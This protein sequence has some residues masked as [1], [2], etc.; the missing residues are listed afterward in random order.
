MSEVG[1]SPIRNCVHQ[2]H[3]GCRLLR[4][5]LSRGRPVPRPQPSF[6]GSVQVSGRIDL[7]RGD[8][9]EKG[10]KALGL[11]HRISFLMYLP[12]RYD[13]MASSDLLVLSSGRQG[14]SSVLV[15]AMFFGLRVV[16]TDCNDGGHEILLDD[17]HGTI[18][19]QNDA[20]VLARAIEGEFL[21]PHDAQEQIEGAQ[22][23]LPK[24]VANQFI[25]A[26][27]EGGVK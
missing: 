5:R 4:Q 13:A 2:F 1:Y 8:Q 17:C 20:L 3:E 15:E 27:C 6:E 10:C 7:S 11:E 26:I 22:P 9:L 24:V 18:V 25:A 14:R 23:F 19:L 16:S 12:E 21:I